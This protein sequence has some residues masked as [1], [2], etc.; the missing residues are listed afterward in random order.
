MTENEAVQEL[1]RL[2]DDVV[3]VKRSIQTTTPILRLI[4]SRAQIRDL[5][6]KVDSNYSRFI[7]LDRAIGVW[8]QMPGDLNSKL[9]MAASL[10]ILNGARNSVRTLLSESYQDITAL[11]SQLNFYASLIVAMLALLISTIGVLV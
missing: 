5:K 7:A 3:E 10:S 9:S 4:F 8:T 11:N 6:Q 2:Q 1:T